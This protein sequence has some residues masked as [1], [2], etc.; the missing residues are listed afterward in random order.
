VE[1]PGS[2]MGR[3]L[4][5]DGDLQGGQLWGW[6]GLM[7]RRVIRPMGGAPG[8]CALP[9]CAP[10][11]LQARALELVVPGVLVAS[12][13]EASKEEGRHDL[14]LCRGLRRGS[15]PGAVRPGGGAQMWRWLVVADQRGGVA[16]VAVGGCT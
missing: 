2:E 5:L 15:Q 3:S 14:G 8:R 12:R 6:S 9:G 11:G 16:I 13:G 10:W 4:G 1:C 7:E